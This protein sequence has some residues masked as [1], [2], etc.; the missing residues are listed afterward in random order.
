MREHHRVQQAE[1][2]R[3][4]AGGQQRQAR[5][6]PHPE[7]E[8]A[9]RR[10]GQ[11]PPQVEPVGDDRLEDEPARQRVEPEQRR[12]PRHGAPRAVQPDEP[13]RALDAGGLHAIGQAAEQH[14]VAQPDRRVEEEQRPVRGG[15][16]QAEPG[17]QPDGAG[18]ERARRP[19]QG[20]QGVVDREQ[21]RP[22]IGGSGL[23]EDRLLHGDERADLRAAG[24][25]RAG[26][27]AEDEQAQAVGEREQQAAGDHQHR[28]RGHGPAASEAVGEHRPGD[29]HQR[30]PGHRRGQD[31]PHLEGAQAEL[32]EVEAEDDGQVAVAE[33]A[34]RPGGEEPL[35][36]GL[37]PAQ[38]GST[39]RAGRR[40]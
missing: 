39:A 37:Q 1:A 6:H 32:L 22:A 24:A 9:E 16:G 17:E 31:E 40:A 33:R 5:Q 30:R 25:D 26:Q 11:A 7:E 27:G 12:Q 8:Q 3:H 15:A 28:H 2:P 13:P 29:V 18:A 35:P 14:E 4:P 19:G 10:R 38:P 21:P 34:Q 20:A 23:R 36:V